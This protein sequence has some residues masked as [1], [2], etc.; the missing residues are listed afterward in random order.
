MKIRQS[1]LLALVCL[2]PAAAASAD[3]RSDEVLKKFR[4]VTAKTQTLQAEMVTT[5]QL[6]G[7]TRTLNY[8]IRLMKPNFAQIRITDGTGEKRGA[9]MS[10]G[11]E[12]FVVTDEVKRYQTSPA[13][14]RGQNVGGAG[15]LHSPIAA[16]FN[17]DQLLRRAAHRYVGQQ[18]VGGKVITTIEVVSQRAPQTQRLFFDSAG[19]FEG[20]ELRYS[21]PKGARVVTTMLRNARFGADLAESS[22]AYSPPA[23]YRPYKTTTFEDSLLPVGKPA[24]DFSAPRADTGTLQLSEARKGKKATLLY[25]WFQGAPTSVKE[26]GELQKVYAEHQARGFEIVAV[27]W[28]NP[29]E[30]VKRLMGEQ[31]VTFPVVLSGDAEKVSQKY[32]VLGYPTFYLLDSEGKILWRATGDDH[33]ELRKQL[34]KLGF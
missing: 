26:L 7:E 9:I 21:D 29:A 27:N 19:H 2:V 1:W 4:E 18:S 32:Q 16:F 12:L 14:A 22:F 5:T 3:P 31:K 6:P 34:A 15:G 30:T 33:V 10:N 28:S 20:V 17:P 8:T 11:K 25:F 24:P 13:D 23:G